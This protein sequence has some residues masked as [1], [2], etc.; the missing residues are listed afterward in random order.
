MNKTEEKKQT[1]GLYPKYSLLEALKIGESIKKNNNMHPY[2][3]LDI[4]S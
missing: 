2:N 3:R 1:R 4:A